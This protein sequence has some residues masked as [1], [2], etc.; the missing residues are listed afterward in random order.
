MREVDL[1]GKLLLDGI[2]SDGLERMNNLHR[3]LGRS[4]ILDGTDAD[5]TDGTINYCLKMKLEMVTL[6][7]M[8][9]TQT[10]LI[11][12]ISSMKVY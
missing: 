3:E 1:N 4:I 6:F 9:Q 12:I 5:G 2:N 7:L 8:E 11:V 10:Q